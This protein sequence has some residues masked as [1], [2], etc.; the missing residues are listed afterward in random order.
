MTHFVDAHIDLLASDFELGQQ[1]GSGNFS[2]VFLAKWTQAEGAAEDGAGGVG[3]RQTRDVAV[4]VLEDS[5]DDELQKYVKAEL[6]I[7]R[8]ISSSSDSAHIV[9]YIGAYKQDGRLFVVMECCKGGNLEELIEAH[10]SMPTPSSG[11][12]EESEAASAGE[13]TSSM[14]ASAGGSGGISWAHRVRLALQATQGIAALHSREIIHR[15]VKSENMLLDWPISQSIPGCDWSGT[16]SKA[17][18]AAAVAMSVGSGGASDGDEEVEYTYR[19]PNVKICDLGFARHASTGVRLQS[20]CGT[21][22]TMAPE[23]ILGMEYSKP[24]DVFSLGIVFAH[25]IS[26]VK[27]TEREPRSAFAFDD[28][29]FNTLVKR[30]NRTAA[31]S[32]LPPC[33]PSFVELVCQCCAYEPEDRP[34]AADV[35]GWLTDVLA[36]LDRDNRVYN[37]KAADAKTAAKWIQAIRARQS[38]DPS[39]QA[40]EGG[41]EAGQAGASGEVE[42]VVTRGRVDSAEQAWIQDRFQHFDEIEAKAQQTGDLQAWEEEQSEQ[43]AKEVSMFFVDGEDSPSG[44]VDVAEASLQEFKAVATDCCSELLEK[45]R[46]DLLEMYFSAFNKRLRAELESVISSM[47]TLDAAERLRLISF[48]SQFVEYLRASDGVQALAT[49]AQAIE[50]WQSVA[51]EAMRAYSEETKEMM[52][53][54]CSNLLSQSFQADAFM[55][56]EDGY[57]QTSGSVDL[58]NMVHEQMSVIPQDQH[59]AQ[60]Q[61]A[62]LEVAC[63]CLVEH[64]QALIKKVRSSSDNRSIG[65]LCAIANDNA[66]C[67]DEVNLLQEQYEATDPDDSPAEGTLADKMDE[68]ES[69]FVRA[70]SACVHVLVDEVFEDL[71]EAFARFFTVGWHTG[72]EDLMA[73]LT[74]TLSDYFDD[75]KRELLPLFFEQLAA[76]ALDRVVVEYISALVRIYRDK[77][78]KLGKFHLEASAMLKIEEDQ[79]EISQC[80]EQHVQPLP[81]RF[82]RK[83]QVL[84][85]IRQIFTCDL[86]DVEAVCSNVLEA[87]PHTSLQIYD[88]L[89]LLLKLRPDVNSSER[90]KVLRRVESAFKE[91]DPVFTTDFEGEKDPKKEGPDS[92]D[93]YSRL[94]PLA[95]QEFCTGQRWKFLSPDIVVKAPK[96]VEAVAEAKAG[97]PGSPKQAK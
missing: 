85:H 56:G 97:S 28:E 49:T 22:A 81:R 87:H 9:E 95:G 41:G 23:V 79:A 39:T 75:F 43:A 42:D 36:E 83:L 38:A 32:G 61:T 71:E 46:L 93:V 5:K 84:E 8:S 55:K 34:E 24:A 94:F 70:G 92:R 86:E 60:L 54:W 74:A 48:L 51:A 78:S 73:M 44:K 16:P 53:R 25:L 69:A 1:L 33:P 15:D 72:E 80:F 67:M 12:E 10:T 40:D 13:G 14:A 3:G 96:V 76:E 89:R 18:T 35:V 20:I 52:D 58:F 77:S 88:L 59:L 11:A 64:Q 50:A 68:M 30:Q 90:K 2:S 63:T 91:A 31:A 17:T 7:I 57:M 21:D 26:F 45:P 47:Q 27:P 65:M 29:A 37:L 4:K 6:S 62:V 19:L 82:K 66:K